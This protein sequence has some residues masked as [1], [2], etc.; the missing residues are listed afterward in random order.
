M[1]LQILDHAGC[2]QTREVPVVADVLHHRTACCSQARR[3]YFPL[4]APHSPIVHDNFGN[5]ARLLSTVVD[6]IAAALVEH[7]VG[8][9]M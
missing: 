9:E 4:S 3:R 8:Q 2:T 5:L 1:V 7:I 6:F